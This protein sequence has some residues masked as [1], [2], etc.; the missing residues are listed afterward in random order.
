[1]TALRLLVIDPNNSFCR[2]VQQ[3][4]LHRKGIGIVETA[5]DLQQ[6]L[7]KAAWLKPDYILVDCK[8]LRVERSFFA[9]IKKLKLSLPA[10]QVVIL[11]LFEDKITRHFPGGEDLISGVIAKENFAEKA[12][13]I[14]G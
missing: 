9:G 13:E 5:S 11:T 1:M 10:V 12:G 8:L 4:L 14:I 7:E 2:S 3:Y 6:A